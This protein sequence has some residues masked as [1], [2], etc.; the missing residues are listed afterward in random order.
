[1]TDQ[2]DPGSDSPARGDGVEGAPV[3]PVTMTLAVATGELLG[4]N[5]R[6]EK[7][8]RDLDGLYRDDSAYRHALAEG[9]DGPVYWVESST[10]QRGSG[11]LITGISV[12]EPGRVGDEF[13]M[14]RGHLH[15]RSDRAETYLGLSGRGVMVLES[16]GG[17][18]RAIEVI[19]GRLVYVPGGWIHRSVNVGDDRFATLFVYPEDAGQNYDIIANAGGMKQLI[20]AQDGGWTTRANPDHTGYRL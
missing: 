15:A 6:Y 19:P 13:A 5:G 16:V 2:S 9:D 18:S 1:M 11:A 4:S 20:V 17:E 14:T 10:T 3:E 12:L 7:Q 8:L